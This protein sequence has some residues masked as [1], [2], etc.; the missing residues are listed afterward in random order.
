MS[1]Q[2]LKKELS[3]EVDVLHA[4]KHESFYNLIVLFSMGLAKYTQS[5]WVKIC[6]I[7]MIS[8]ERS[9]E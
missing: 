5:T 7:F 3:Y 8:Y 1:L 6:N 2:Y 9:Y 4:G